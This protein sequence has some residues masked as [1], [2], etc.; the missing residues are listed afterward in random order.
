MTHNVIIY[1][2]F[3]FFVNFHVTSLYFILLYK[4]VTHNVTKAWDAVYHN[5]KDHSVNFITL[6]HTAIGTSVSYRIKTHNVISDGVGSLWAAVWSITAGVWY[7][8]RVFQDA[9]PVS[10]VT[11][12]TATLL[13]SEFKCNHRKKACILNMRTNILIN[14][15][16]TYLYT[17][18]KY[19]Y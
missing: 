6:P 13:N 8:G 17:P 15:Y 19:M 2:C 14:P 5:A 18:Y 7:G 16:L 11:H 9:A 1:S 12:A 4:T 10:V 3:N